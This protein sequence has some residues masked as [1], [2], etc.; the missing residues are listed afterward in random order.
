MFK[1]QWLKADHAVKCENVQCWQIDATI[2]ILL[3][4]L[5]KNQFP[6]AHTQG[7]LEAEL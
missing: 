1:R 2:I 4:K 7:F 5:E 3:E 6:R